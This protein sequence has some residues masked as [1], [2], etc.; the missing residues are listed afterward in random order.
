MESVLDFCRI[1]WSWEYLLIF[2]LLFDSGMMVQHLDKEWQTRV[3]SVLR[4]L[5]QQTVLIVSQAHSELSGNFD[6]VD[7][8]VKE[9]DASSIILAEG[10]K[11]QGTKTSL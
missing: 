2:G 1:R 10:N 8:V 3:A 4:K 11:V 9:N 5:P 6:L 7:W